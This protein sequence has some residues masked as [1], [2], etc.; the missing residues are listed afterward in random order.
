MTYS[1]PD[2]LG[3]G[4]LKYAYIQT[5]C[6]G[7]IA[8][9]TV[10]V[11]L[12]LLLKVFAYDIVFLIVKDIFCILMYTSFNSAYVL[13]GTIEWHGRLGCNMEVHGAPLVMP[14]LFKVIDKAFKISEQLYK[15][16]NAVK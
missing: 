15:I 1:N 16:Q 14:I 10:S 8:Y 6:K 13:K 9:N 2:P 5:M 7:R 11:T 12:Y 4:F 3:A